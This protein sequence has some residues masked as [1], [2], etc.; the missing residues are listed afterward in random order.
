MTAAA[1]RCEAV[2][3]APDI[4]LCRW[5]VRPITGRRTA[6]ASM[7]CR[8]ACAVSLAWFLASNSGAGS[9]NYHRAIRKA[10]PARLAIRTAAQ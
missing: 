9:E 3:A 1:L 10:R 7:F 8:P 4:P 5:C 2:E 6:V